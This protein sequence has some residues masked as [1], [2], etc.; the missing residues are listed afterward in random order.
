[1]S[2]LLVAVSLS[3]SFVR[4]LIGPGDYLLYPDDVG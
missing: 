3:S 2:D 1:M 4:T